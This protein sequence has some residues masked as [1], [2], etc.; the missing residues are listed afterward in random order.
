MAPKEIKR[1]LK[2]SNVFVLSRGKIAVDKFKN[3][4][5]KNECK[6]EVRGSCH[7]VLR[8]RTEIECSIFKPAEEN[9][10]FLWRNRKGIVKNI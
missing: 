9:W 2:Y 8:I 3:S 5:G 4:I 6:N 10:I 7:F 1:K